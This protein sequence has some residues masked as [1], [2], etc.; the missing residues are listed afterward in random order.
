MPMPRMTREKFWS[1][2]DTSPGPEGCWLWN[3]RVYDKSG[4]GR[5]A[6]IQESF[7]TPSKETTAHRQAYVLT[8]GDPGTYLN[9]NTGKE[10]VYQIRHLCP[11][12]PNRLCCNPSH[13]MH[14]TALENSDDK[15]MHG[16]TMKGIDCH[17]AKFDPESVRTVRYLYDN[18][19]ATAMDLSR[20][21]QVAVSCIYSI[22]SREKWRH[23]T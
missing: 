6:V 4:Y 22:V 20:V 15:E 21:Y 9:P 11:G 1:R 18:K 12:Q 19:I 2:V 3:H 5:T 14:G 23:V 10:L 16:N 13:L 7:I 17:K 8:Y